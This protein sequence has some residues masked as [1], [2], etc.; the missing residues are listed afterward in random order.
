MDTK[1]SKKSGENSPETSSVFAAIVGKP[2][3]GKSSL[4]NRLIGE[5]AAI[6]TPKP[7]TTRT[8]VT[9]IYT[10]GPVQYVFFD[11]PGFHTPRT[12]LGGRMA[13]TT[14][15]SLADVDAVLM[16]FE[17]AGPIDEA[18]Q[19]LVEAV[20]A[21]KLP[22]LGIVNKV[23]A[24]KSEE[25]L[26]ARLAE[27]EGFS[28]FRKVLAVS[29]LT[30]QGCDEILPWLAGNALAGPHYFPDDAF[31]DMPEKELVA[32]IVR[33]KL[34]LFLREEIPHG[35]A[36]EVDRFKERPEGIVDIDIVVYCEKKSH[37]G[38]IIGKGGQMLKQI[39]T[40]ARQDSEAL[41]G[42]RVN[43]QCW[44]KVRDDWRN[45]ERALNNLGFKR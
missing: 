30:G 6:V 15:D 23:D 42:T 38:M 32:E 39:A 21:S 7:Q 37:K 24:S 34:L 20:R 43:L 41:L 17:P 27:V 16:L 45:D 1:N 31:T 4:L 3:V 25:R 18:E 5:K 9:G 26:A 11:T 2:N 33:E 28:A 44:V 8:R 12:K 22:A 36:V 13:K 29:A 35:T 40:A 19:K 14:R 10:E